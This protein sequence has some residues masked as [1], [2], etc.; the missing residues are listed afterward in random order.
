M[1]LTPK[2]LHILQ[3][4]LGLDEYGQGKAFRNHYAT[5]PECD[6]F[7]DCKAL[8]AAGLMKDHGVVS[9]WGALHGFTVTDAGKA[10]IRQQSP[11][12]PKKTR[13][14]QRYQEF[15]EADSSMTFGEYLKW[16]HANRNRL[17]ELGYTP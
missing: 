14:Q 10:A 3:H 1:E 15:L 7:N 17:V 8:E 12:P 4:S 6:S 9:M 5:G 16:R 11:V 2:Q 13:A